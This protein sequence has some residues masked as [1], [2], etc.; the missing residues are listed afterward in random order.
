TRPTVK[1]CL[2]TTDRAFGPVAPTLFRQVDMALFSTHARVSRSF[3]WLLSLVAVALLGLSGLGTQAQVPIGPT[4]QPAGAGGILWRGTHVGWD[5]VN[6]VYLVV[7]GHGP[8]AGIFVNAAGVAVSAPF[9]IMDGTA[10]FGHFPRVRYSPAIN[11]GAG[12]FLVA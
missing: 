12:G 1:G 4:Q 3:R 9:T 5:P 7:A 2:Q 6:R 11:N 10:A 8:I